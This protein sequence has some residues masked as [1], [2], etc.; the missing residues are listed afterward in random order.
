MNF[1]YKRTID[2]SVVHQLAYTHKT[3]N[4]GG[5]PTYLS[6]D[7]LLLL[8]RKEGWHH[9]GGQHVVDQLKET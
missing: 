6:N 3:K 2:I 1:Q 9:P 7:G 4:K 8:I 5:T